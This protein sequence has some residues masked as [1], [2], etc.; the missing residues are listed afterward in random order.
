MPLL[1][2]EFQPAEVDVDE[3]ARAQEGP[4]VDPLLFN[5]LNGIEIDLCGHAFAGYAHL[6]LASCI[7]LHILLVVFFNEEE[8][9]CALP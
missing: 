1:L 2:R 3:G 5:P 7:T 6:A 9:T 8:K 4:V